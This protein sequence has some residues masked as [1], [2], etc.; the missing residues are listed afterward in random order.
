MGTGVDVA[1]QAA[2]T[3]AAFQAHGLLAADDEGRALWEGGEEGGGAGRGQAAAIVAL[4]KA[5]MA[6]SP[7]ATYALADR[8][9]L[10]IGVPRD[11]SLALKYAKLAADRL[12][13]EM[14]KVWNASIS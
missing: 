8:F 10:G 2:F 14:E 4:H 11:E 12:V 5:A 3:L 9:Y 13:T 6:G 7:E 1:A